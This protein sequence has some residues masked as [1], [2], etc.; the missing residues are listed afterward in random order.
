MN[1]RRLALLSLLLLALPLV[2]LLPPAAGCGASDEVIEQQ[3][4]ED[5]AEILCSKWF[6]CWPVVAAAVFTS[7]SDCGV[8]LVAMC[9]GSELLNCEINNDDLRQCNDDLQG[10]TCGQTPGTCSD[11]VTCYGES[12]Q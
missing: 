6:S 10:T 8:G 3:L 4:C 7:E 12:G 2:F 5:T 1:P 11:I 9:S